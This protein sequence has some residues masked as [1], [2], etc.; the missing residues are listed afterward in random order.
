[1]P[2]TIGGALVLLGVL[3]F[4]Q[5]IGVVKG[6]FMTS[7]ALWAIIGGLCI[8]AGSVLIALNRRKPRP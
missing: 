2:T 7:S 3:W 1:M 8:V 4:F 6:S 5:G